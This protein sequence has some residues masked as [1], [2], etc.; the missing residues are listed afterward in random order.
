MKLFPGQSLDELGED[1]PVYLLRAGDAE[2][3]G[4]LR[5]AAFF[6][7]AR[8][9]A[10]A[11]ADE[12]EAFAEKAFEWQHRKGNAAPPPPADEPAPAPAKASTKKAPAKK[13]TT[14]KTAAR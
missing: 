5:K 9:G 8:H 2:T 11:L 14:K 13:T 10:G 1:E 7:R 6:Y 3:P 12:L 4:L